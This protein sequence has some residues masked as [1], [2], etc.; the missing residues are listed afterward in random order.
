MRTFHFFAPSFATGNP[1]PTTDPFGPRLG[2]A[3]GP[4]FPSGLLGRGITSDAP[5]LTI[6]RFREPSNNN[7]ESGSEN[8]DSLSEATTDEQITSNSN[9]HP[10]RD[11]NNS[12]P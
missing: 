2:T 1:E 12:P 3:D 5:G 4:S 6:F 10:T 7:S 8:V 9:E 11:F